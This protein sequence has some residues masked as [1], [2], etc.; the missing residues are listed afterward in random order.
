M[1]L[2]KRQ[3]VPRRRTTLDDRTLHHLQRLCFRLLSEA[4]TG[5]RETGD[6]YL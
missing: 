1:E 5:G 6:S 4:K 2:T 3:M